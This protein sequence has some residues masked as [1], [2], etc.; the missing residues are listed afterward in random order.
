MNLTAQDSKVS[1]ERR[2]LVDRLSH[3]EDVP[4]LFW[5]AKEYRDDPEALEMA[6]AT[7]N[8]EGLYLAL[9]CF[10]ADWYRRTARPARVLDLCAATGLAALRVAETIPLAAVTLVDCDSRFLLRARLRLG[11][12]PRV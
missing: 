12:L 7:F 10:A 9:T 3:W 2:I 8:E 4:R 1:L 6:Q 11:D 5:G